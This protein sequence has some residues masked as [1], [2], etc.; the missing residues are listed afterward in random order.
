MAVYS[1]FPKVF[2][3]KTER[4]EGAMGIKGAEE[5]G[6]SL[7][8][9]QFNWFHVTEMNVK[10]TMNTM[11]HPQNIWSVLLQQDEYLI[12]K[13]NTYEVEVNHTSG[14]FWL[15]KTTWYDPNATALLQ[16]AVYLGLRPLQ[17]KPLSLKCS[18]VS[19]S[20]FP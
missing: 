14:S 13:T 19:P 18:P 20:N 4:Q 7:S 16:T 6:R 5:T 8:K 1:C 15:L 10:T 9:N 17:L 3:N 2:Q 11:G 12:M